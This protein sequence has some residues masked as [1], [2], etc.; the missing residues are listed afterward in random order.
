MVKEATWI[1]TMFTSLDTC[2]RRI[3]VLLN[4]NDWC[5]WIW[6]LL[7]FLLTSFSFSQFFHSFL[8][9]SSLCRIII[10]YISWISMVS[11]LLRTSSC[12]MRWIIRHE[13]ILHHRCVCENISWTIIYCTCSNDISTMW[14]IFGEL[15]YI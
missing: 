10:E 14:L 8:R 9:A 4:L 6:Y 15:V 12:L 5:K 7:K 1:L 3:S 13:S 11:T 2:F